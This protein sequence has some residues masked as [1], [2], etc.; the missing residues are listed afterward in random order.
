[1][2]PGAATAKITCELEWGDVTGSEI[3]PNVRPEAMAQEQPYPEMCTSVNELQMGLLRSKILMR[4]KRDPLRRKRALRRVGK[5]P[6]K[7]KES[8]TKTVCLTFAKVSNNSEHKRK[9]DL[10]LMTK[11]PTITGISE[12]RTCQKRPSMKVKET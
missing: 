11:R 1:V 6:T 10:I 3:L 8:P 2:A 4:R 7:E 12:V 9:R 5:S